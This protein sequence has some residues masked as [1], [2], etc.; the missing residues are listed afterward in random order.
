MRFIKFLI[1]TYLL[2]IISCS[3]SLG[4]SWYA[5][6]GSRSGGGILMYVTSI[7]VMN[8]DVTVTDPDYRAAE[9]DATINFARAKRF[10]ISVPYSVKSIDISALKI[11]A[12]GDY[13]KQSTDALFAA[14]PGQTQTEKPSV[15]IIKTLQTS[16]RTV[17]KCD[18][19][20]E[21]SCSGGVYTAKNGGLTENG[22]FSVL[23][24]FGERLLQIK[25]RNTGGVFSGFYRTEVINP[26]ETRD[27]AASD[28]G[29][30]ENKKRTGMRIILTPV[31]LSI[32]QIETALAKSLQLEL[33][34]VQD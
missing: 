20:W 21:L 24:V 16:G 10:S 12:Y 18:N 15:D 8:K 4:A 22:V 25:S 23:N 11:E 1:I 13:K 17:W 27:S 19:G 9:G 26:R 2:T 32:S 5:K 14:S 30:E 31:K 7:K 29:E 3:P 28:T 33:D 34:S 6:S